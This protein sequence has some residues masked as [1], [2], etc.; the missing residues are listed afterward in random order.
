MGISKSNR[1][2]WL[3]HKLFV[4]SPVWFAAILIFQQLFDL[5]TTLYLTSLPGGQET[6]PF[7]SP[8]W[9]APGGV[10][11]LVSA[12][13]WACVIFALGVPYL[14][15]EAPSMMW[16]PKVICLMYWPLILWNGYL[17]VATMP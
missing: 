6:N 12:K 4:L 10:W 9:N 3:R 14:A 8:M 5:A 11:W 15:R 2:M 1:W 13:F 7:L 16:A 17:V